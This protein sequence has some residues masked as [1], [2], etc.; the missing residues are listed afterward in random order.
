LFEISQSL[1]FFNE[2][3]LTL[4]SLVKRVSYQQK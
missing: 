1:N 3:P 2:I 4:P